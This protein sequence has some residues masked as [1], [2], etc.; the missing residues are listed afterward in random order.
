MTADTK[1]AVGKADGVVV[2][3]RAAK[4]VVLLLVRG[5]QIMEV[6]GQA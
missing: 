1:V 2:G 6:R 4:W 3:E 5:R